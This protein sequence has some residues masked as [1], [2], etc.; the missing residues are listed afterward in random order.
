MGSVTEVYYRV[1]LRSWRSRWQGLFLMAMHQSNAAT[2]Q[3]GSDGGLTA[4]NSAFT[5]S[6]FTGTNAVF[7]DRWN[8]IE[9]AAAQVGQVRGVQPFAARQR[10]DLARPS[11]GVR[12]AQDPQLALRREGPAPGTLDQ[13]GVSAPPGA[14]RPAAP[15]FRSPTARSTS[16]PP[17]PLLDLSNIIACSPI[18]PLGTQ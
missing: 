12:L 7:T 11:T 10:A 4:R 16:R 9:H 15:S 17:A 5:D 18:S 8:R 3:I 13:L 6:Y 14:P 2:L 1:Y